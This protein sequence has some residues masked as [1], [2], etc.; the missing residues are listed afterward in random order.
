MARGGELGDSVRDAVNQAI[1]RLGEW[2][3]LDEPDELDEP[4]AQAEGE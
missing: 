4:A 1:W 2:L 3:E